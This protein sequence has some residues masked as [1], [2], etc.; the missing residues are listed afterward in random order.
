MQLDFSNYLI[1][2]F[3]SPENTLKVRQLSGLTLKEYMDKNFSKFSNENISYFKQKI[4]ENYSSENTITG[5]LTSLL[6]NTFI[7]L[8][9]VENWPNL[10]IFLISNTNLNSKNYEMSLETIQIILEDYG[11]VIEMN[12]Y[13][14]NFIFMLFF[15]EFF[16]FYF[17]FL[18]P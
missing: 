14:V 1:Y 10:F 8:N 5:K 4:L 16:S 13:N 17:Y 6:I 7:S 2:I 15:F 3:T 12:C 9:G 18:F 11:S